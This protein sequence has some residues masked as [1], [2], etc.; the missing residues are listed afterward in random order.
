MIIL[1]FLIVGNTTMSQK[2]KTTDL[3]VK[4]LEQKIKAL[5]QERENFETEISQSQLPEYW[6]KIVREELNFMKKGEK[7]FAFPVVERKQ[8][9]TSEMEEK[10]SLL[11]KVLEKLKITRE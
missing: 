6:E 7:V 4:T 10:K 11:Q 9:T 2:R 5:T 3:E 1:I 8:A